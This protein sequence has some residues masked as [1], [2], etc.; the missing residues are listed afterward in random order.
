MAEGIVGTWSDCVGRTVVCAPIVVFKA[1]GTLNKKKGILP[2]C[3]R[4][5]LT[6]PLELAQRLAAFPCPL[7]TALS[8][9]L[10]LVLH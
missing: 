6:R 9:A 10:Q 4:V 3:P 2:E 8:W 1:A 5:V 7:F